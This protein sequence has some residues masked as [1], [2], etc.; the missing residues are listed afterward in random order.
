MAGKRHAL[1][2]WPRLRGLVRRR[3]RLFLLM[4]YDGTLTPIRP[5]PGQAL[6]DRKT[7][8]LLRRV[9]ARGIRLGFVSGRPVASLRRLVRLPGAVYVGNHGLEISG[10]GV[11]FT[12]P[13]AL[14]AVPRLARIGAALERALHPVRGALVEQKRLSLSVH[15][16]LVPSAQRRAFRRRTRGVL[17]PWTARG[18]VRVA[19]GKRV[20]EV[21]PPAAWHKGSAVAWLLRHPRGRAGTVMYLGDDRTDEDAFRSVNRLGGISV[22][23]GP[24][25]GGSAARWWLRNPREVSELLRRL[26]DD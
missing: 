13:G 19:E 22:F 2:E 17:A 9:S 7:R 26:S 1:R 12:H 6:L 15:W 21:R 20:V 4:D 5:M 25:P 11:A 8:G 24:H 10:P 3:V 18:A 23:V 14:R 16:R